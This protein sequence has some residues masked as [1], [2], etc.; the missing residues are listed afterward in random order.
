MSHVNVECVILCTN[1]AERAGTLIHGHA[2]V[3]VPGAVTRTEAAV[4]GVRA[5]LQRR[6][7]TVQQTAVV[8]VDLARVARG[9][10]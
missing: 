1:I 2:A 10:R 4:D 5:A 9:W 8:R 6:A 3:A 7:A